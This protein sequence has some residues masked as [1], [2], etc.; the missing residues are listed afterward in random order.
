MT[1]LIQRERYVSI[2]GGYMG[3]MNKGPACA[4]EHT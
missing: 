4:V 1:G 3:V 2:I